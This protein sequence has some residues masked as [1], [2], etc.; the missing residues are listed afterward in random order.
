ME[1]QDYNGRSPSSSLANEIEDDT[2]GAVVIGDVEKVPRTISFLAIISV[3]FNLLSSWLV[4]AATMILGLSHGGSVTVVYGLIIVLIMYG[5]VA[6][7]LSEMAA[8]YPTAGGQYH[9]TALLA[10]EKTKRGLHQTLA[11]LSYLPGPQYHY[12][13][14]QS[15]LSE[16]SALDA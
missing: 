3:A 16:A 15:V 9:W 2:T 4:V 1:A 10:P 14:L 11:S 12:S 13:C 8:R 7:S 6:L 5:A